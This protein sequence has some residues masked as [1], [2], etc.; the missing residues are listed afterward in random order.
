MED[1]PPSYEFAV[2]REVWKIVAPWIPSSDLCSACLVSKKWHSIFIPFLWGDP[3]SHFGVENDAVYVALTRFKRTLK[4]ARATVRQLTHTLHLPPALSEIYGGPNPTWLR[5]VL[6]YLPDLQSLIVSKLPFFDHHSLLALRHSSTARRLSFDDSEEEIPLFGLKLLLAAREPNSTSVSLAEA[7]RHF[8]QLVY[9]DLSY[10]TPARDAS[11]LAALSNLYDLQVLKLRG[12]GLR[13]G[14]AEV[15]ANSIGTRVRLLDVS[16]NLLT[17]MAVRS[18]LQACFLPADRPPN[19]NRPNGR[20]VEDWPIGIAP[21]PDFLSLDSLRSEQLD[22]ELL[23]QLMNP[24]TGRLAFEDIP[25]RGL[26]HLYIADNNLSVEGLSSL[27]KTTRLHVLDGGTVDT[28]KTIAR[29]ISLSSPTGYR[30]EISFPGAEKLI[31]IVS[32]YASNNLTYLRLDHAVVTQKLQSRDAPS[33]TSSIAELPTPIT[34]AAELPPEERMVF[35]A[36][37]PVH[38]P[39]EMPSEREPIFELPADSAFPKYELPGDC[40]HFALSPPIGEAPVP[41]RTA[42]QERLK[43]VKGD[44]AFAP[45]VVVNGNGHPSDEDSSDEEVVLNAS[46]TGRTAR[47]TPTAPNGIPSKAE[48][49]SPASPHPATAT[50]VSP[51]KVPL[52]ST[53]RNA[54]MDTILRKRPIGIST[55]IEPSVANKSALAPQGQQ[56]Q[57]FHPS[58]LPH[59]R[60]L[61][62][63]NVPTSVP[64]SSPVIPALRKFISACADEAQLALL[65]AKTNYSLPPGRSRQ[66]AEI[67][68]ARSLFALSLIVLEITPIQLEAKNGVAR[69]ATLKGW[70]HLRQRMSMSKSSTGDPDS[71]TFW[72]AAENDFSFFGEEGE[73][74]VECGIYQHDPEK[75]FP[76]AHLD[77]K[78]FVSQED[79]RNGGSLAPSSPHGSLRSLENGSALIRSPTLLQSPRN[80]PLGRNR[81][82]SSST[83][84][85]NRESIMAEMAGS[86]PT[87]NPVANP[88]TPVKPD[89]PMLDVVGEL[90]KFRREKK[91]EY[92][93]ALLQ[94]RIANNPHRTV[95]GALANAIVTDDRDLPFVEGHWKGEI[96]VVRN[97]AP[98]GRTGVVD[99]YGNYFE[100][101]YLYP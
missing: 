56:I 2:D 101:G 7:L 90:A 93:A 17:D 54:R 91:A 58:A 85:R 14:E 70:Q 24:L 74:Q 99:V 49:I 75:Y 11:V 80:L 3:A 13:D 50:P 19:A 47:H 62:L 21:G 10:T 39:V 83:S 59:L 15:L 37:A 38:Y 18:L 28:V 92:E 30:D 79:P 42:S 8:P 36:P 98:K 67:H 60:T 25:H 35:E 4:R 48:E 44:G 27:L 100:K 12:V 64:Q 76:T 20:Q 66:A 73:E 69:S 29:T 6:E 82:S 33:P 22:Q 23:K 78:I 88:Q 63:T 57:V 65:R 95:N 26:T 55:K 16:E 43:P 45:E 41:S 84:G 5:D 61:I 81:R 52:L 53:V 71:E 9:L 1:V 68:H 51:S 31:P 72:S 32:T 86:I 97:A 40:I 46:G 96:R 77:D 87:S 89:E 34:S 94:W